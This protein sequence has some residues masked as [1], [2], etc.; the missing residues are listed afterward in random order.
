[1]TEQCCIT[2]AP[3]LYLVYMGLYSFRVIVSKSTVHLML[4]IP[5]DCLL[6]HGSGFAVNNGKGIVMKRRKLKTFFQPD[7][8]AHL[9]WNNLDYIVT[10]DEGRKSNIPALSF[11]DNERAAALGVYRPAGSKPRVV[12]PQIRVPRLIPLIF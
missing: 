12:L 10:T 6:V 8:I 1:M 7:K 11:T 2:V 5:P 3:N 9:K 4:E